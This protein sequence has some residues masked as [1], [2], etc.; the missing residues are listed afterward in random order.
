MSKKASDA[1]ISFAIPDLKTNPDQA[2][3]F[4]DLPDS[5]MSD[6]ATDMELNGQ[7]TAIEILPD[8]TIIC[9]QQRVRAAKKLGWTHIKARIRHDL[10]K[11]GKA[12]AVHQ[13]RHV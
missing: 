3:L 13:V 12:V 10:A 8:G 1:I 5:Q 9:G 4:T 7:Q 11:E 6:L 2:G